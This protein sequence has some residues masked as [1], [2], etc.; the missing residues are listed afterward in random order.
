MLF[1]LL[2]SISGISDF[3]SYN[4]ISSLLSK[5]SLLNWWIPLHLFFF[6]FSNGS[7]VITNLLNFT[8]SS[9]T[10]LTRQHKMQIVFDYTRTLESCCVVH[11]KMSIFLKNSPLKFQDYIRKMFTFTSSRFI[12]TS[13]FKFF[14]SWLS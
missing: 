3:H 9:N 1:L 10:I 11:T 13:H 14:T 5:T 6:S 4:T 8:F 2:A 7:P 12:W